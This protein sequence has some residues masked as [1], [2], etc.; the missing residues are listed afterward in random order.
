MPRGAV[1][2]LPHGLR[3]VCHSGVA[4]VLGKGLAAN[5][6]R[7]AKRKALKTAVQRQ[8][9]LEALMPHGTVLPALPGARL[10]VPEVADFIDGNRP[11]LDRLAAR[12]DQ[13]VQFQVSITWDALAA[14]G[15]GLESE[16]LQNK[17]SGLL[18]QVAVDQIALPRAD[19]NMVCNWVLLIDV[20]DEPA[21][22]ATL[23]EIDGIWTEGFHIK[24]VGPS[25]ALSFGSLGVRQTRATD[26]AAATI[27]LG[28]SASVGVQEIKRARQLALKRASP[29]MRET[30]KNAAETL[31]V[32]ARAGAQSPA[33][34]A[35]VWRE[36]EAVTSNAWKAVA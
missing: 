8:R 27:T 4:A 26:V 34:M 9:W 22:D 20:R 36:G 35:F 28:V 13:K 30:I 3:C 24:V 18:A 17:I 19:E 6:L 12:L 23:A 21:L 15:R 5:L 31:S 14:T 29:A 33:P 16:I 11:L 1:R 10:A 25:P 2:E 7:P 32:Q